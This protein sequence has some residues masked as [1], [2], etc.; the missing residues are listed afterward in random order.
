MRSRTT[1]RFREAF[2]TLSPRVQRQARSAYQLFRDDPRHPGLHFKQVHAVEDDG[3]LFERA[4]AVNDVRAPESRIAAGQGI[5]HRK[6]LATLR[7]RLTTS[8][9]ST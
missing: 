6:V 4:D 7:A 3:A 2:S 9:R 1:A 5:V 8:T